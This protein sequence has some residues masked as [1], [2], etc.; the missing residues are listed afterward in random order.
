M[1]MSRG[2]V[3]AGAG[4]CSLTGAAA[5]SQV[6]PSWE[7]RAPLSHPVGAFKDSLAYDPLHSESVLRDFFGRTWIW[8]GSVWTERA[9]AGPSE[10]TG[11]AMVFDGVSGRV[12]L[13]GGYTL[14]SPSVILGDMWAWNGLAW[15]A[16]SPPIS[17]PPMAE[18][19]MA[20]D[21]RRQRVVLI[22]ESDATMQTWEWDGAGW[23]YR[24]P[25][26][27]PRRGTGAAYDADRGVVVLFGGWN[28]NGTPF[29][30][31]DTWEWDGSAWTHRLPATSPPARSEHLMVYD[32]TRGRTVVFGGVSD[33]S[34][35]GDTWEWDGLTWTPLSL[36]GPEP[37]AFPAGAFDPARDRVVLFGGSS[38]AP[39][40][41]LYDDT[42][43]L[44]CPCYPDCTTD[45]QLTVADF[46]CFQTKFVAGDP[47]ADCNGVGG[48]TIA[49][50]GCF[51][52]KFVEGCP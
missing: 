42:W 3:L 31:N 20:Y 46:G 51:Q 6:C 39:G 23:T 32:A 5:R 7:E 9:G 48:L 4:I 24:S 8:N 36:A 15:E 11:H 22:G 16:L 2:W 17:P 33:S 34:Y 52:T 47:Y 12:L 37:R 40:F 44:G 13:F 25:A 19:R 43:E 28:F 26:P 38:S 10:R 49:D 50:F 30:M 27:G 41:T 29:A 35:L 14:G 21:N 1:R 18:P 45:A